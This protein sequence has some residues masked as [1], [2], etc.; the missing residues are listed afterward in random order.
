MPSVT[1]SLLTFVV[2]ETSR[3]FCETMY[4]TFIP[5]RFRQCAVIPETPAVLGQRAVSSHDST[6]MVEYEN[7]AWSLQDI[8]TNRD[9]SVRSDNDWPFHNNMRTARIREQW[10]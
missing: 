3:L 10:S 6:L 9:S 4:E 8:A 1:A 2:F 5:K 7:H